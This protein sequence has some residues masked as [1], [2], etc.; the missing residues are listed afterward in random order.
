M[1]MR[2]VGVQQVMR[3]VDSAGTS[4]LLPVDEG[5]CP[6][7]LQWEDR[8]GAQVCP[9]GEKVEDECLVGGKVK[10]YICCKRLTAELARAK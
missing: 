4:D 1:G 7:C 8:G 5:L 10:D 6:E 2:R 3:C 9:G